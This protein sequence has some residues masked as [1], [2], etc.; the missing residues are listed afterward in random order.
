MTTSRP[1]T[2][3]ITRCSKLQDYVAS[4]EQTGARARILEVRETPRK[5]LPKIDGVILTRRGDGAP[6]F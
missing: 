4:V 2:I 1:P 5:A 3:G 6:V